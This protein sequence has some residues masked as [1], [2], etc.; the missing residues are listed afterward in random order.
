MDVNEAVLLMVRELLS[1]Y[2]P[3][4]LENAAKMLFEYTDKQEDIY[5]FAAFIKTYRGDPTVAVKK[6]IYN[7]LEDILGVSVVTYVD[8]ED[9]SL[10]TTPEIFTRFIIQSKI[11][12][13]SYPILKNFL[14]KKG[15]STE[16][17]K[18]LQSD[19]LEGV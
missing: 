11:D 1:P 18:Q 17:I 10:K 5:R 8:A 15:I 12:I 13:D 6:F 16:K 19:R 4:L 3:Q 9:L 2:T 7:E 14:I